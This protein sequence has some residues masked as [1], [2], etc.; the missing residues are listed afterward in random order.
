MKPGRQFDDA[1]VVVT[2][3]RQDANRD[4]FGPH[5]DVHLVGRI[6]HMAGGNG[7]VR[8]NEHGRAKIGAAQRSTFGNDLNNLLPQAPHQT[9]IRYSL[10][11]DGY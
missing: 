10:S 3:G 11:R 8:V 9:F 6:E 2:I 7:P 5:N 4:S 1:D